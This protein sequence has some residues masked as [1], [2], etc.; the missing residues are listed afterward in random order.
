MELNT[1]LEWV[2][3]IE[4]A[5]GCSSHDLPATKGF[6][7]LDNRNF[8]VILKAKFSFCNKN[9]SIY[10]HPVTLLV[11]VKDVLDTVGAYSD[12][13]EEEACTVSELWQVLLLTSC[14][15]VLVAS[16]KEHWEKNVEFWNH[17]SDR[18]RHM[19]M[20]FCWCEKYQELISWGETQKIHF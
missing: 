20:L 11:F 18:K 14:T 4:G 16:V 8:L 19:E 12:R 2:G 5:D 9:S 7:Y 15:S 10:H 13:F 6:Y 1:F 17:L 3:D